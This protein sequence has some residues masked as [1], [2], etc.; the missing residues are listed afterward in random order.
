MEMDLILD[1]LVLTLRDTYPNGY[2]LLKLNEILK[3]KYNEEKRKSFQSS[4]NNAA[5]ELSRSES[6]D[7]LANDNQIIFA[8]AF[9]RV[10]GWFQ[11]EDYS[12]V[13]FIDQLITGTAVEVDKELSKDSSK[14]KHYS[15]LKDSALSLKD[16]A[17]ALSLKDAAGALSLKDAADA[18]SLKNAVD[19]LSL[20]DAGGILFVYK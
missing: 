4:I 7:I 18:L 12:H 9:A 1:N 8:D 14:M 2:S 13:E 16:A 19:S 17:D 3:M 10:S 15:S 6:K 11:S 20:K 5:N